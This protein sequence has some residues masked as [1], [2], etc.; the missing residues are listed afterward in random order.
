VYHGVAAGPSLLTLDP[1]WLARIASRVVIWRYQSKPDENSENHSN[2]ASIRDPKATTMVTLRLA[3][4]AVAVLVVAPSVRSQDATVLITQDALNAYAMAVGTI[5]NNSHIRVSVPLPDI[6]WIIQYGDP[7]LIPSCR[8]PEMVM[9]E[10]TLHWSLQAPTFTVTTTGMRFRAVLLAKIWASP[11]L[12]R[13]IDLPANITYNSTS[14]LLSLNVDSASIPLKMAGPFGDVV[15]GYAAPGVYF[16][17]TLT[18]SAEH[19][20]FAS[21]NGSRTV[22]VSIVAMGIT[23][24]ANRVVLAPTLRIE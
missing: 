15:L 5:T 20:S 6:C 9:V 10:G 12:F 1:G 4:L 3:L 11:D 19:F 7:A 18:T 23:Y 24:E 2:D 22:E 16:S 14:K 21:W 8:A 17:T 13:P